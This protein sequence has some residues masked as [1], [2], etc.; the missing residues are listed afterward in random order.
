MTSRHVLSIGGLVLTIMVGLAYACGAPA[1]NEAR[2]ARPPN[3]TPAASERSASQAATV[4]ATVLGRDI[5]AVMDRGHVAGVSVAIVKDGELAWTG[6]YGLAD[7]ERG[8]PVTTGTL[9][10]AASVSKAVATLCAV[11]ALADDGVDLDLDAPI[12]DHLPVSV[13]HPT[14]PTPITLR[15]LLTHTAGIHDDYPAILGEYVFGADA[16]EPLGDYLGRHLSV[17]GSAYQAAHFGAAPGTAYEYSNWGL[18]LAGWVVEVATRTDFA[19]YCQSEIFEPMGLED[20]HWFLRDTEGDAVALPYEWD[21]ARF[22]TRGHYGYPDYPDGQLRTTAT[23]LAD[24]LRLV[25][26]RGTLDGTRVL[27]AS[28]VDEMIRL[29]G[30][31]GDEKSQALGWSYTHDTVNRYL[32]HRGADIG[33]ATHILIRQR[34]QLGLV[35]LMNTRNLDVLSPIEELL[36]DFSDTL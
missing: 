25:I 8:V 24:V 16:T 9:F 12:N 2:V 27:P 32:G 21:G 30:A 26:G 18:T 14:S 35:V 1:S 19:A 6:A 22:H 4:A 13:A 23:D 11:A 3:V 34:D 36:L 5:L 17:G 10:M 33:V 15:H 20:T 31:P 29:Q 28:S 7:V